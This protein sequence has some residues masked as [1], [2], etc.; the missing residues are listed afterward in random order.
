MIKGGFHNKQWSTNYYYHHDDEKVQ[1]GNM[2]ESDHV[3]NNRH[4]FLCAYPNEMREKR[5]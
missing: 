5:R 1:S 3:T 2:K 4:E